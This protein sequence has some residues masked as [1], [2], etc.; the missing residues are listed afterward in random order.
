MLL[1]GIIAIIQ[2]IFLP[3]FI[4]VNLVKLKNLSLLEK[5]LYI[6]TFSLFTNY[7]LVSFLTVIG[8]YKKFVLISIIIVELL[9]IGYLIYKKKVGISSGNSFRDQLMKFADLVNSISKPHVM[10]LITTVI[11]VIF[12]FSLIISNTGT[13]FYF[14]DPAYLIHLNTWAIDFANNTL[15]QQTSHFPQLIP[16]NWSITYLLIGEN[17]V[18]MFPKFIMPLFFFGNLIMFIDLAVSKRN[19]IYLIA[20]IIYGLFA[21][22][23][24]SLVFIADGNADLPVSFF[25]FLTFYSYLKIDKD[26]FYIKRHLLLFLFSSV[27]AATKL[28][29]F[30]IFTVTSIYSLF[31]LFRNWKSIKKSDLVYILITVCVIISI[32]LF[33]YFIKPATMVSGLHQPQWVGTDYGLIFIEAFILMY[34]NWGL[35]IF[36][37]L[38]ITIVSALFVKQSRYIAIIMVVPPIIIWM[39]KFSDDFR[40]LSFVVPFLSYTSAFG[41][42]NLI[43]KSFNR[44]IN[45]EFSSPKEEQIGFNTKTII[46]GGIISVLSVL[47]VIFINSEFFYSKL[48]EMY[49]FISIHYFQSHRINL[50]IDYTPYTSIDYY[51][52][53]I[54]VMLILIPLI[55]VFGLLKVKTKHIIITAFIAAIVLNFSFIKSENILSHQKK[56][57][58]IVDARNYSTWVNTIV[59]SAELD[60][61]IF[62]NF[63]TITEENRENL[64]FIFKN[65]NELTELLKKNNSNVQLFLNRELLSQDNIKM[66]DEFLKENRL[67]ILFDDGEFIL[68]NYYSETNSN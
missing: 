58:E 35:P 59:T 64:N 27:A 48:Y 15:P 54:G 28:A 1:V 45:L 63:K 34:Y 29:G 4:I 47:L 40:N 68:Y 62:T 44:K 24:Y 38:V 18:Q 56:L 39:F 46:G 12:Y 41:L 60:R 14:I 30:Y 53:T 7:A 32:S 2:V 8:I 23:I 19:F 33:W 66:I 51:Q 20:L 9:V 26:N 52:R 65:D 57:F 42:K 36:A 5:I 50:L 61:T 22:V 43:E 21:P 31:I 25:A 10:I 37:F 55:Y 13:I 67:N 3:G 17:N 16:A 49:K 11:V 6:F